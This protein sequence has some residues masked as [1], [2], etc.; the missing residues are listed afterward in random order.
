MT[1]AGRGMREFWD[2]RTEAWVTIEVYLFDVR[3]AEQQLEFQVNLEFETAEAAR[4]EVDTYAP[5]LGRLPAALLSGA[6][7]VEIS[8]LDEN[9]Q[10]N[11]V[12]V[13]HIYTVSGERLI[14]DGFLEEVLFHEGGHVSLD[15]AHKNSAGWRAAQRADGVFISTYARDNPWRE[16]VAESILPYFA[17]RYRPGRLTDADR[18]AIR[19]AIPNR[20]RYFEELGLDMSPY[21]ATG[22]LAAS[23][24]APALGEHHFVEPRHLVAAEYDRP[25]RGFP[26]AGITSSKTQRF[27]SL[28]ARPRSLVK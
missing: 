16:D 6:R 11:E 17:V 25:G 10:G 24:M 22:S 20:L 7:E 26:G 12:G 2:R 9:F 21:I 13:F 1:Y 19:T 18:S 8:R 27:E 5:A 23:S 14:G 3:Y 28:G 15:R 4:L